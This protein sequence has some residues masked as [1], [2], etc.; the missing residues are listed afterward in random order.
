MMLYLKTV[1]YLYRMILKRTGYHERPT[2]LKPF[3]VLS[4]LC[5]CV[6]LAIPICTMVVKCFLEPANNV[7]DIFFR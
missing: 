2:A 1:W 3:Y 7:G 5:L 6:V 4:T